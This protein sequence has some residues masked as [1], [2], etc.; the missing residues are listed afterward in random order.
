LKRRAGQPVEVGRLIIGL[1]VGAVMY[2][3]FYRPFQ[4]VDSVARDQV[5]ND[6]AHQGFNHSMTVFDPGFPTA[7]VLISAIGLI[8]VAIFT[9]RRT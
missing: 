3:F 5:T 1:V 4:K 9:R 8:M 6:T 7:I 2:M